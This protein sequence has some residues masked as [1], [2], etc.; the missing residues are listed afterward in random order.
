M[1]KPDI[2]KPKAGYLD[3][4]RLNRA[5]VALKDY[6]KK[7]KALKL[8]KDQ[9]K[10][11]LEAGEKD[12]TG[13]AKVIVE[14][15][16]KNI[17]SNSRTYIHTVKLPHHWR[18]LQE[19]EDC[20]IA[21]FV[22]HRRA[23]TEA[24]RIQFARDR[25]LD[26]DNTHRYYEN[27]LNEKLDEQIRAKISRIITTKELATEYN[28]FQK[29]DR[30]SKT[31]DLFLA[32]KQLMANKMNPLPRRLG[33]RFWVREKKVP[34]MVKMKTDDLNTRF[35]N[36]LSTEPFYIL[37]RSATEKLQIG[38]LS[39]PNKDLVE[40]LRA[41]LTKL[42]DLYGDGVRFLRLR[43]DWGMSLPLFADLDPSSPRVVMRKYRIKPKPV[44]D[45]FDM[46]EDNAKIAVHASGTVRVLREK[47][48]RNQ[49]SPQKDESNKKVKKVK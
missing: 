19:P 33:R 23:E 2:E 25:D 29:L 22:R 39:Q 35:K 42:H 4:K 11:L 27:L 14:V 41:F 44:V 10:N 43:T 28:T 5:V 32:D 6:I 47:R 45:D 20:D 30:L 18:W 48:K 16:F 3:D 24:Q 13:L 31:F 40:N 17:P 9:R 12:P 37:G 1:D 49:I 7:S 26:I 46:L 38:L 8:S 36:A 21:L 34:L 15:V